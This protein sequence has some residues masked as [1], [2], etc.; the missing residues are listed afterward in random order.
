MRRRPCTSKY[1]DDAELAAADSD[2]LAQ[3]FLTSSTERKRCIW[4]TAMMPAPAVQATE[5]G[6]QHLGPGGVGG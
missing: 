3:Q 5:G 2:L 1:A 6:H 4:R